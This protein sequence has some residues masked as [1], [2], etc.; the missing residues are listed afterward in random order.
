MLYH[1]IT[2]LNEPE[3]VLQSPL[4]IHCLVSDYDRGLSDGVQ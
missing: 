4:F 1:P 2:D 3:I